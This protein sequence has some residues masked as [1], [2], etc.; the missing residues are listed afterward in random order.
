MI[1]FQML[2]IVRR[3]AC[4]HDVGQAASGQ[5]TVRAVPHDSMPAVPN[6]RYAS[7]SVIITGTRASALGQ[8]QLSSEYHLAASPNSF[9]CPTPG[10]P[11]LR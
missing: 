1:H 10:S 6:I 8:S 11:W 9:R 3:M 7:A 2:V 5:V 4:L